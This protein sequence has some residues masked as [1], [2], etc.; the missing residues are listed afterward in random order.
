MRK[1]RIG[2][3]NYSVFPL[4]LDPMAT[5]EWAKDHGAEGVAFSGVE[6]E[7]QEKLDNAYLKDLAQYAAENDLYLEWGGGQHIPRDMSSWEKQL[8]RSMAAD[9]LPYQDAI[10]K[11]IP[12]YAWANRGPGTM[13]VWLPRL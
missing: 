10:L 4:K 5:L 2:I 6:A 12:Y 3:D 11:A 7:F 8:Y 13:R 9:K 1:M